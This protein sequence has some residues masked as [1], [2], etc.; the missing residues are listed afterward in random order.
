M[1][2]FFYYTW[3]YGF[4]A[5]SEWVMSERGSLGKLVTFLRLSHGVP[6]ENISD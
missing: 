2:V 1:W 6:A 3:A 4:G 5:V